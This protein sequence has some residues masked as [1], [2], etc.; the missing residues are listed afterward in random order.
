M[1]EQHRLAT[2]VVISMLLLII[3]R[4]IQLI[5]CL[6]NNSCVGTRSVEGIVEA[7]QACFQA[8]ESPNIVSLCVN[9]LILS[10]AWNH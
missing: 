7:R 3:D 9:T 5:Q 1:S 8:R 4:S 2:E 6:M 10:C